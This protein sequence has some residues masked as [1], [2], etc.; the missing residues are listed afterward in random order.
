MDGQNI[1]QDAKTTDGQKRVDTTRMDKTAGKT[2]N[3]TERQHK[4]L[5]ATWVL[6]G[7]E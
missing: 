2:Y 7:Q 3:K 5:S 1:L 6:R 4:A